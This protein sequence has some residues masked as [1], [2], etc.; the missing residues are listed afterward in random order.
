MICWQGSVMD[1]DQFMGVAA[2]LNVTDPY[3]IVNHDSVNVD[4]RYA[5]PAWGYTQLKAAAVAW[6][7]YIVRMGYPVSHRSLILY[8]DHPRDLWRLR[9]MAIC[10]GIYQIPRQP[11]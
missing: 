4:G 1:F 7:Q 2:A 11:Q 9:M 5:D 6:L 8:K 10:P 3:V